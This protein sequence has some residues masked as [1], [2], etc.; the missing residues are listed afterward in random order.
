MLRTGVLLAGCI[1]WAGPLTAQVSLSTVV[2]QAQRN[3]TA[4]RMAQADLEKAIQSLKETKDVYIPN[5]IL[6]SSVGPPSIGFTFSQPSIASASMQS[7]AYSKA[8]GQYIEAAKAGVEAATLSL[9]DAREQVAMDASSYYVELDAV[10]RELAAAQEQA[11]YVGKLLAIEQQRLDAGVD[12]QRDL[13]QAKLTA[14]QL[15]LNRLHLESRATT[16]TAQLVS[17]TGLPATSI[18]TES[19]S[20]PA[21]PAVRAEDTES[22]LTAGV[23]AAQAQ[24]K[25]HA[26]QAKG[27]WLGTTLWPQIAFGAQYNRDATSLNNYNT[28]FSA[29]RKFKADNFSTGFSIQIP[30]FDVA[31]RDKARQSRAEALR[32]DLEADQAKRQ[33]DVQIAT[34]TGNIRELDALAEIASLKQQIAAEQLK[35]VETQLQSGNGAGVE[36]GAPPQLTPKAEQQARIDERQKYV[37]ALDAGFDVD[38]ARLGLLR[39]LGRMN[40]WLRTLEPPE[41]AAQPGIVKHP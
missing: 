19:A 29:K 25:A 15:R 37:D 23:E 21:I 31:R 10:T 9:K 18:R 4:V 30:L 1:C 3:S 38:K 26:L 39:A 36:P 13:L 41:S 24:A 8:Q 22:K 14:A 32:A 12:A 27:D 20:I 2:D 17:L 40:E 34:L 33:N 35:A 7:L 11:G 28:Y 16:L 6:G 5:L